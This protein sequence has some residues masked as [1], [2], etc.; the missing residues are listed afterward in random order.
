MWN[1]APLYSI[2]LKLFVPYFVVMLV[3]AVFFTTFTIK[4]S[5][6]FPQSTVNIFFAF[7]K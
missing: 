7:K 2:F 5:H 4:K 6:V 3:D 1:F